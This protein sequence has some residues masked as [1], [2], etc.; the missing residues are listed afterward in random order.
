MQVRSRTSAASS[1][2]GERGGMR[3][4]A[5]KRVG[6]RKKWGSNLREGGRE[7]ER[8]VGFGGGV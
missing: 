2:A 8:L 6:E 7:G 5:E 3:P 1:W 4:A